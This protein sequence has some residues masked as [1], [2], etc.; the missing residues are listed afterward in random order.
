MVASI[1]AVIPSAIA[2]AAVSGDTADGVAGNAMA[3]IVAGVVINDSGPPSAKNSHMA[4]TSGDAMR[5]EPCRLVDGPPDGSP[6]T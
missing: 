1:G 4:E 3:G 2:A 5:V 6:P